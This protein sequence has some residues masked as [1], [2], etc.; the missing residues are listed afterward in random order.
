[1]QNTR[2][3]PES[4][5]PVMA[6]LEV[7]AAG[8]VFPLHDEVLIGRD[9]QDSLSSDRF[10]CIPE[11]TVSRRHARIRLRDGA[12]FVEDLHSSNGTFVLGKRLQ[13]GA[14]HPLRDG[15][16]LAVAAEH[17][18]FHSLLVPPPESVPAMI[19]QT[20][21]ATLY[22]RPLAAPPAQTAGDAQLTIRKLHAMAQVGI[23]VGAVTNS[24]TL[25]EKIMN[26]IFELFPLA[27]R[28]FI[29]LSKNRDEAPVQVAARRRDGTVDR[30]DTLRLS[31]TIVAEV[32]QNKLAVLSV[33][34][35]ADRRFGAQESIVDQGIRSVMC[36]PLLLEDEVLGLIQVDTSSDPYAF[37]GEDLQM[38]TGVC[39][40]MAVAL[41]NFQLYSDIE[42]LLEGFVRASVQA[43]EERDPV[44]AGH[45]FRVAHYAEGLAQAVDRADGPELRQIVFTKDQL[46]EIR[47]AA[48]LHDFGKVGV[49]EHVLRKEKKLH[50]ADMR[51]LEQRFKYACACLERQAY[52]QL[53]E[54]QCEQALGVEAFREEKRRVEAGLREEFGR[55]DEFLAAIRRA[56]EPAIS[57]TEAPRE[58]DAI[59]DYT[60]RE[61]D[62][63]AVPLLLQ[64]EHLALGVSKGCLT[65]EERK[66]IESHVADTYSFLILIP[67]THDL[68]GVPA[69][70][71]GHHE[72]LDGSGYP[73]GLRGGQIS[74]QTRI[75][76][77]C[78]IYDAL[79]AGDRPYKKAVPVAEALGLLEAECRAGH[80]DSRLFSVFVESKVWA[81]A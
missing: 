7:T 72:K 14:W 49:R 63:A 21:D 59:L 67:W 20:V 48:L 29:L 51:M 78:D 10:L 56:N 36:A 12:Y 39:A 57:Y 47:Y 23:A 42:R 28:A 62:G 70:A 71:H 18:I 4:A 15:D 53:A 64:H 22:A 25:I 2:T 68:S 16:E 73:M 81:A 76:T 50:H 79:T 11:H 1:M 40:E 26:L 54:R 52:R 44:T 3:V 80:I 33:D 60:Y 74:V 13:P 66:Q 35:L 8:K 6:Y 9:P 41:K 37:K 77:I 46:R 38:L 75:L 30:G 5:T 17:I 32:L 34:T 58:L 69:I 65:A 55:L 19:K 31:R 61:P 27:E 45:S 43:I 24:E